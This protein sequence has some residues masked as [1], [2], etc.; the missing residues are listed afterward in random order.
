M[1]DKIVNLALSNNHS[2][3]KSSRKEKESIKINLIFS[4]IEKKKLDQGI[5]KVKQLIRVTIKVVHFI[6]SSLSIF[7]SRIVVLNLYIMGRNK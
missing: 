3:I 7:W 2:P 5:W 1:A 6:S 4:N